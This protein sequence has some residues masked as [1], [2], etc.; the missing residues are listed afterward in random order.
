MKLLWQ[1]AK[2]DWSG[3][4]YSEIKRIVDAYIHERDKTD[5]DRQK[6]KKWRA[7]FKSLG[8]LA[9]TRTQGTIPLLNASTLL[10]LCNN[11]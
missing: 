5:A 7:V 11:V 10:F 9:S 6:D 4:F 1:H 3:A 2:A 8:A